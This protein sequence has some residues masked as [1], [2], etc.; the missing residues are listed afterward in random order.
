VSWTQVLRFLRKMMS[1]AMEP[2][3]VRG[4][5][6]ALIKLERVM[7]VG[8]ECHVGQYEEIHTLLGPTESPE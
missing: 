3:S 4:A 6:A 2:D 8:Q 1:E 7:A 5:K